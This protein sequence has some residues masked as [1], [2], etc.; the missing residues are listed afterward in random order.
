V[1]RFDGRVTVEPVFYFP[2]WQVRC[3]GKLVPT[4]SDP[5]TKLLAY[6]GQRCS[7]TIDPTVSERVGAG[8]SLLGLL[9]VLGSLVR[10]VMRVRSG[11]ARP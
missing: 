3:G 5:Q 11:G 10:S 4:F 8:V 6:E 1:A 7:R 9:L 2:S